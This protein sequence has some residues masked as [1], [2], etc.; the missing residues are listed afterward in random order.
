MQSLLSKKHFLSGYESTSSLGHEY[1]WILASDNF[2]RLCSI[3]WNAPV[4]FPFGCQIPAR[5]A[6]VPF[7]GVSSSPSAPCHL[8]TGLSPFNAWGYLSHVDALSGCGNDLYP[9]HHSHPL[10]G[11]SCS[12]YVVRRPRDPH[13]AFGVYPGFQFPDRGYRLTL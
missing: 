7:V 13:T 9:A 3:I 5:D 1:L 4:L 11:P 8:F 6:S 10:P 12:I 2:R